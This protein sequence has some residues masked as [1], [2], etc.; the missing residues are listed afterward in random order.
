[1]KSKK[2]HLIY[3]YLLCL[4]STSI[5]AQ[6][7]LDENNLWY[8]RTGFFSYVYTSIMRVGSDTIIDNTLYKTMEFGDTSLTYW[9]TS[10]LYFIRE[11]A[12]KEVFMYQSPGEESKL[13]D[14]NMTVGDTI[15]FREGCFYYV[16]AVDSVEMLDSSMRKRIQLSSPGLFN[17]PMTWIE[18]MGCIEFN[19]FF[20]D[21]ICTTDQVAGISCYYNN[22][23][24]LFGHES[25]IS[26][27][28]TTTSVQNLE[29]ENTIRIFPNPAT[30]HLYFTIE[31]DQFQ[32]NTVQI[33]NTSGQKVITADMSIN[34]SSLD[35]ST[36][37]QGIYIL[38][39]ETTEG[40]QF[41]KRI[42]VQ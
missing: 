40:K 24:Q 20:L 37:N 13:Y 15:F 31:E 2:R 42:F 9:S 39:L 11:T 21:Y 27:Y 10:S 4:F 36:L 33:F 32:I 26:C 28:Y 34:N 14:F 18:G 1:M 23:E 5:T 6:S 19:P 30:D 12:E 22:G 3:L 35:I 25:G 8:Y 17:D 7:M 16:T 38:L 41:S 29:K